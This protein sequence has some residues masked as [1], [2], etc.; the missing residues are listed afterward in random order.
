MITS[1][2]DIPPSSSPPAKKMVIIRHLQMQ[3]KISIS[4][5]EIGLQLLNMRK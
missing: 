1:H 4:K 5:I 3:L 2:T